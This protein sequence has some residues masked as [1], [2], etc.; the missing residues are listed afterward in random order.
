MIS[1]ARKAEAT[2]WF[3][4]TLFVM[5]AFAEQGRWLYAIGVG[6]LLIVIGLSILAPLVA[7]A[8]AT[9]PRAKTMKKETHEE[10]FDTYL[11][12]EKRANQTPDLPTE[13]DLLKLADQYA[14]KFGDLPLA[15]FVMDNHWDE[16]A[17]GVFLDGDGFHL[18]DLIH[19]ITRAEGNKLT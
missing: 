9:K 17:G 14:Q 7:P 4:F 12:V 10:G 19:D 15:A 3:L 16:V 6:G 13:A 8:P 11:L 2:L 18:Q 5:G 1:K